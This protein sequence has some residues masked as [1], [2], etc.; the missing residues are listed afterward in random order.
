MIKKFFVALILF[1]FCAFC[2]LTVISGKGPVFPQKVDEIT[3]SIKPSQ[4]HKQGNSPCDTLT[5]DFYDEFKK[6]VDSTFQYVDAVRLKRTEITGNTHGVKF[7][8]YLIFFADTKQLLK[9]SF[10]AT[11]FNSALLDIA[12]DKYPYV[13]VFKPALVKKLRNAYGKLR[14]KK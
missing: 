7:I 1:T 12:T 2:Q 6:N 5:N 4:M 8:A 9:A 10:S 14:A 13:V 11:N 3:F